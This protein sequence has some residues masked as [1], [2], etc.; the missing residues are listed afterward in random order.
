M[1]DGISAEEARNGE[2]ACC[3]GSAVSIG[4]RREWTRGILS[5]RRPL[6]PHARD[7]GAGDGEQRAGARDYTECEDERIRHGG[8]DSSRLIGVEA[9]WNVDSSQFG[10]VR[11]HLVVNLLRDLHRRE[12]AVEAGGESLDKHDSKH[13]NREQTRDASHGVVDAG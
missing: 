4:W 2:P 12:Y 10:A 7:Q 8:F 9:A 3:K 11:Q 6:D 1:G 5:P 13:S